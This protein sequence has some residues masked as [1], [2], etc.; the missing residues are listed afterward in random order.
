MLTR[1]ARMLRGRKPASV[2]TRR[3]VSKVAFHGVRKRGWTAPKKPLGKRPSLAIANQTRAWLSMRTRTA[4]VEAGEGGQADDELGEGEAYLFE[5]GRHGS[6]AG[7]LVVADHAGEDGADA[8]VE[9][10][11]DEQGGHDPDRDVTLGV[12]SLF[13]M[14][15]D[16]VEPDEGE[17]EHAGAGH[18]SDRQAGP[19]GSEHRL[20]EEAE[21]TPAIGGEGVPVAGVDEEG[22]D[23]D[24]EHDDTRPSG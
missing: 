10:G 8:D 24:D 9:G 17:E 1:S 7:E 4:E 2:I 3:P 18:H 23:G 16:R 13:R 20:A 21:A 22:A 14:G 15:R 6:A 19:D 12:V 11:A 5:G